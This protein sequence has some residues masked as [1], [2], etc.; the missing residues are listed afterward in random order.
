[1]GM[2]NRKQQALL[3]ISFARF[4]LFVVRL[5]TSALTTS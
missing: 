1:M 3:L 5:R 2:A 4:A